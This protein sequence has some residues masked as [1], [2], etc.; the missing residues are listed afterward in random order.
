MDLPPMAGDYYA[1]QGAGGQ[2]TGGP[3]P[4]PLPLTSQFSPNTSMAFSPGTAMLNDIMPDQGDIGRSRLQLRPLSIPA[5][6]VYRSNDSLHFD[7]GYRSA[8]TDEVSAQGHAV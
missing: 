2:S 1:S 5:D 6:Q 4:L 3:R 7:G 8:T